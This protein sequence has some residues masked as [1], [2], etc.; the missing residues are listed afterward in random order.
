MKAKPAAQWSG[1]FD[2]VLRTEVARLRGAGKS[3]EQIAI[4]LGTLP[5]VVG[6]VL[7]TPAPLRK[8]GR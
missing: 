8:C 4:E 1:D 2:R 6:L 3:I 7:A 5:E